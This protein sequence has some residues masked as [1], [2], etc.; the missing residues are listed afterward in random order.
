MTAVLYLDVTVMALDGGSCI[1]D[2][3]A[4]EYGNGHL[5]PTLLFILR[6]SSL[7]HLCTN[8]AN[9]MKKESSSLQ[10][11]GRSLTVVPQKA[12]QTIR[13][14]PLMGRV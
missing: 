6:V 1:M 3:T 13:K 10:F 12:L 5:P 7:T 9:D 4:E 2:T 14:G 11:N 8:N